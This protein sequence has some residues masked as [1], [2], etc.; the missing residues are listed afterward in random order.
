MS[1][2]SD[3]DVYEYIFEVY[4]S[5]WHICKFLFMSVIL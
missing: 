1:Y 3:F 2:N 4:E 5:N